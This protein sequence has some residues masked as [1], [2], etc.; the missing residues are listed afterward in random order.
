MFTEVMLKPL[1]IIVSLMILGC[2]FLPLSQCSM[3]TPE[4]MDQNT[5][6]VVSKSETVE[7]NIVISD[8]FLGEEAE[9]S[10]ESL[11]VLVTF[12]VPLVFSLLP[13]FSS[14]RKI[15]KLAAQ[16]LF[17]MWLVYLSYALVFTIG[18]PLTAG[19][20]LMLVSCLFLMLCLAELL[21]VK[22]KARTYS[23][24]EARRGLASR[25]FARPYLRRYMSDKD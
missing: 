13:A 17:G 16:T 25:C 11:L 22:H 19:W 20:A 7:I 9:I 14:W 2:M 4:R 1:K 12:I 21:R 24:P 5:G 8:L 3:K 15:A 18:S 23:S 6:N 10:I